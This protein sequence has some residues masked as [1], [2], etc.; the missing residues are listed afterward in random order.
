MDTLLYEEQVIGSL[1]SGY[2]TKSIDVLQVDDFHYFPKTFRAIKQALDSQQEINPIDIAKKSE[3]KLHELLEIMT[4]CLPSTFE[5]NVA[6]LKKNT[7]KIR[8]DRIMSEKPDGDIHEVIA[9]VIQRLQS[10][11]LHGTMTSVAT[12]DAMFE[13]IRELDERSKRKGKEM[14]IDIPSITS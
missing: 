1:L 5:S 10:I 13:Y 2:G 7:S 14:F 9:T 6:T 4:K 8:F 12:S 11:S 3:F